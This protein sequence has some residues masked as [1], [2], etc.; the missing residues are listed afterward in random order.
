ML[1]PNTIPSLHL[2]Q[3]FDRESEDMVE[4]GDESHLETMDE[5]L[6][7]SD[8]YYTQADAAAIESMNAGYEDDL[9]LPGG[10]AAGLRK[11]VQRTKCAVSGCIPEHGAIYHRVPYK[12]NRG[13]LIPTRSAWME[14]CK[15]SPEDNRADL[16]I[17]NKHFQV[18][19]KDTQIFEAP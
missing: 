12:D 6:P 4:G 2:P 17:C 13:R 9:H 7:G 16:R 3:D 5:D 18:I 15:I 19:E 1:L 14:V 11:I 8:D 10:G